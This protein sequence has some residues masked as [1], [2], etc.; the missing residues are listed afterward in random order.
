MV[1]AGRIHLLRGSATCES[2][3]GLKKYCMY[4]RREGGGQGLWAISPRGRKGGM[5]L[6]SLRFALD[7]LL[8]PGKV[9]VC[10]VTEDGR[11]GGSETLEVLLCAATAFWFLVVTCWRVSGLLS[12]AG[13]P[14]DSII[15]HTVTREK[16]S[17]HFTCFSVDEIPKSARHVLVKQII[18]H[19]STPLPRSSISQYILQSPDLKIP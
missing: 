1:Q 17:I 9:R 12:A 14:L 6:T 19:H 10:V 2:Q 3:I 8:V 13:D 18:D 15:W 4:V 5:M 7:P 11:L 16:G